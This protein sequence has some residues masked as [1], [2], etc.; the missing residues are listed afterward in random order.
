MP[1]VR[2]EPDRLADTS[3]EQ[4]STATTTATRGLIGGHNE[5]NNEYPCC[6][7]KTTTLIQDHSVKRI[8]VHLHFVGNCCEVG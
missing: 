6:C 4:L 5:G 7:L 2:A 8:E 1:K 3:A